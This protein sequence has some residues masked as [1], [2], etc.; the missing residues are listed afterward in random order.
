MSTHSQDV[1][2]IVGAIRTKAEKADR[3]MVAIAGP[4]G[5][6]KSTLAEIIRTELCRVGETAI[7]VPMDGFHFDDA[8]LNQRGHR[9]RKGAP[10]TFDVYGFITL[11]KRIRTREPEIAIP[12]FHREQ[13]IAHA[14]ERIISEDAQIVLV[15]GN[16]LLLNSP[17]WNQLKPLFDL[18]I[19]LNVPRDELERRLV[20]RWLDH[21]FDINAAKAKIASNDLLNIE[22]V[23]GKSAAAD[24]N[25]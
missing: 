3:F 18:T 11:L 24:L 10:F 12:V 2:A 14:G 4:P 25:F 1:S 5:S 9:S 20:Q 19:A 13:E 8:L 21:G 17:P 22:E 23:I 15:E 6:G 16:Y 7:V